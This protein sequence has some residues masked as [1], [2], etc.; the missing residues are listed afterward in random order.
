MI[1]MASPL[2]KDPIIIALLERLGER[3]G[4][5]SFD[6]VDHWESDLCAVGIASPRDHGILAYLSC[7]GE[8][9]GRYHVELELPPPQAMTYS[10]KLQAGSATWASRRWW[11]SFRSTSD[12]PDV[13]P[14]RR[15][16]C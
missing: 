13:T 8:P 16:V 2:D 11:M 10:I 5:D 9:E 6:I 3:L 12:K 4:P 7:Y 15:S 14:R 1:R